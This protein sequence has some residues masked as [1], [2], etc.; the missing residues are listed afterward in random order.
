MVFY[1]LPKYS[2]L[3]SNLFTP[4]EYQAI[5]DIYN[6]LQSPH[7]AQELLSGEKV[8]TLA[9]AIPAFEKLVA[10]WIEKQKAIPMLSH[11]IGVGIA[12][13]QEYVEKGRAS[14]I[15]ALAMSKFLVTSSFVLF[16][17][18]SVIHPSY[19]LTWIQEHWSTLEAMNAREWMVDAVGS[20]LPI[21]R[22]L[23]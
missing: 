9:M 3:K 11:Y 5:H 12:K 10:S 19:K 15:Y 18:S 7:T 8:P 17:I 6:I 13:I 20:L 16:T 4:M 14:R 1:N 23:I 22:L 2:H 21:D